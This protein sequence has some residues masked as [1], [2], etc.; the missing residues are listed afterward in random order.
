[1]DAHMVA[2]ALGITLPNSHASECVG[3]V[4]P[5]TA[6]LTYPC[7]NCGASVDAA[8]G[9]VCHK[10]H[11]AHSWKYVANRIVDFI[12]R[13]LR[14]RRYLCDGPLCGFRTAQL[15]VSGRTVQ[16]RTTCPGQIEKEISCVGILN[17]LSYF[18]SCF[19]KSPGRQEA[20]CEELRAYAHDVLSGV[21]SAHGFAR[22]QLSSMFS[23]YSSGSDSVN[24]LLIV[25]R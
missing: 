13:N 8:D 11:F 10:C 6:D 14:E 9:L 21:L 7:G 15:P 18:V 2:T 24:S 23:K 4:I 19:E 17:T 20:P 22:V 16:H 3:V 25:P 12:R 1:M 5:H